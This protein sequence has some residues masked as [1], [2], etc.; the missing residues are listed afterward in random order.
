[1]AMVR[2]IGSLLALGAVICC[3]SSA[4]QLD[5]KNEVRIVEEDG[6]RY[7]ETRTIQRRPVSEVRTE[8]REVSIPTAEPVSRLRQETRIVQFPV[9]AQQ[10]V[11]QRFWWNPLRWGQPATWVEPTVV[12]RP[13]LQYVWVPTPGVQWSQTTRTVRQTQ[14]YLRFEQDEQVSRVALGP[15]VPREPAEE[16]VRSAPSQPDV[17]LA[18]RPSTTVRIGGVS[19]LESDR[20]RQP[21]PATVL[22]PLIRR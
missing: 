2:R 13:Q 7:R 18:A 4:A 14:R 15:S 1:M 5:T 12:W 20:L 8:D 6:M 17:E 16:W 19:R 21:A 9:P 11:T 10:V 3:R 22:S